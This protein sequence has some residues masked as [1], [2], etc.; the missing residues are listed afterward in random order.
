MLVCAHV[1]ERFGLCIIS[2]NTTFFSLFTMPRIVVVRIFTF[3]STQKKMYAENMEWK[4][5]LEFECI[6]TICFFSPIR[7]MEN[8]ALFLF[9]GCACCALLLSLHFE[10]HIHSYLSS[11]LIILTLKSQRIEFQFS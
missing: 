9:I 4:K 7:W 10:N 11:V 8:C 2:V 1:R 3:G 6:T 5:L